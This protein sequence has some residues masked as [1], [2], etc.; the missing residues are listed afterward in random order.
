ML[1]YREGERHLIENYELAKADNFK[2]WV[3]HHRLELTLDNNFA[4]NKEDLI[5]MDMYFHRPYYELIYMKVADHQSLHMKVND[6]PR[7]KNMKL[8]AR[9]RKHIHHSA[10]TKLKI[11]AAHKGRKQPWA[12]LN[13]KS[14]KGYT[15]KL[16]NGKRIW[17]KKEAE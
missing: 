17:I 14:L 16:I 12:A 13:G 11:G 8:S 10:A 3:I 15:W 2:G 7:R 4:H 6:D 9:K 1:Y 5:R